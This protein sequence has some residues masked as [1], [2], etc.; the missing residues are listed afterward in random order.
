LAGKLRDLGVVGDHSARTS[1][2]FDAAV[3]PHVTLVVGCW[4]ASLVTASDQVLLTGTIPTR[5]P[6]AQ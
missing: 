6:V 1:F 4:L 3:L 2:V 5:R